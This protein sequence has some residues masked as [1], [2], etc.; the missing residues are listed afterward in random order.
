MSRFYVTVLSVFIVS[1]G[2]CGQGADSDGP[3][4]SDERPNFLVIYTDDMGYTDLGAF[5]GTDIR[6]PNLD[7]LALAGIRFTNFHAHLSCA[8][9]RAL[10]M[11]GTGNHEAGLGTQ[12]EV[13]SFR[14]QRGYERFLTDR[15]ATLP[16]V[17]GSGGY[18]TYISGKWGLG[19]PEGI[20]PVERGFEKSFVLLPNGGGHYEAIFHETRYTRNGREVPEAKV[21]V[22]STTLFT[23]SL[24][25]FFNE[26]ASSE[27]PFF[28]LF[29]P[30]APHW[31]L[32]YPPGMRDAYAGAYDAGYDRLR[33]SR[34]DGASRA[35]VLPPEADTGV[36]EPE[37]VTWDSL[38]IEEQNFQSQVMEI[39]A[40]MVE[41]L[42][43]EIGRLLEQM[44]SVGALDNT[45][46]LFIN[47][48]GAQ[49]GAN[50]GGPASYSRGREF[51][52][53]PENI[54]AG[55]SWANMGQGWADAVTAPFRD[56]KA[57]V[58]EG[59]LR[60][61]AFAYWAGHQGTAKIDQHRLSSMD[62]MPTLLELA[63]ISHP[64][65]EL[66]GRPVLPLR[67]R[68]FSGVLL[69]NDEPVHLPDEAIALSSS[70]QH[71]MYRG[72][73]KILK[74]R[75]SEWELYNIT[76]DPYEK[77]NLA[78]Q[79]SELLQDLL[80]DF[81]EQARKSNILD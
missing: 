31:P 27:E 60:V 51:D 15:V 36:Y 47:D 7:D 68:S 54:G 29:T 6:T 8:P 61:A 17:L 50:F 64:A 46:I 10:L 2:A 63:G 26:D 5:G 65:P 4:H 78:D 76:S 37:A 42:D 77:T 16:E 67:G 22:F 20:D 66:D 70:G 33:Q 53:R 75:S 74:P 52:N 39:Y 30:T 73:W 58:Y 12:T 11:S 62:V 19:G 59:G 40:S 28:A 9:S 55:S 23:D 57:S 49:G 69:G 44:D 48:N 43:S 25:E 34:I 18:R 72:D 1:I 24:I 35:G 41:H 79:E 38:S 32:H 21:P 71:F 13:L 56:G 14:G 80:A 81:Q 45:L 3:G